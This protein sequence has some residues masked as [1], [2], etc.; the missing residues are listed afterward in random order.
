MRAQVLTGLNRV[1]FLERPI[2]E[3]DNGELIVKVEYCGICG[4][5]VHSYQN[6]LHI[7]V[8]AVMGHECVGTVYKIT[9]KVNN[10][11]VG[12]R[13]VI[14]PMPRCGRCHWCQT[15]HFSL[16]PEAASR[17]IGITL[18]NDGGFAEFVKIKYPS[19]MLH[20]IPDTLSFEAAALA[21][22]LAVSLHGV[23]MSRIKAGDTALVIGAGM[24]GLGVIEFLRINGA[25]KIIVVEI[26]ERKTELAK[27]LGAD[28]T[29]NPALEGENTIPK[30]LELTDGIGPDI[31]FECGGNPTTFQCSIDYVKR[32]GQVVLIGFCEKEVPISPLKIILKELEIKAALGYDNEFPRVIQLLSE[33]EIHTEKY[34]SGTISLRDL[35]EG[36]KRIIRTPDIIKLLVKP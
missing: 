29:I 28:F 9:D 13:V 6:G 33:N 25:G 12:D 32:G 31:V 10:F 3:L 23:R 8:G 15:G 20:L 17:E 16:C 1:E 5:D 30:I 22:P 19:E 14:N 7:P 2:T 21:E 24:I 36:L 18:D 11:R 34:I 4:T 26:S 35:D 27:S